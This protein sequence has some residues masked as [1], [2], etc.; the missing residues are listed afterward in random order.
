MGKF[1]WFLVY[2]ASIFVLFC[3][4]LG[5]MAVI[6]VSVQTLFDVIAPDLQITD[7]S[8]KLPRIPNTGDLLATLSLFLGVP[9]II[10]KERLENWDFK[11]R[12]WMQDKGLRYIAKKVSSVINKILEKGRW[13]I[14]LIII[15]IFA[16]AVLRG[17]FDFG[18]GMPLF[19]L[20]FFIVVIIAYIAIG[21][22]VIIG[23]FFIPFYLMGFLIPT[24]LI[25]YRV[26]SKLGA[27]DSLE[28]TLLFLALITGTLAYWINK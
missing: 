2:L 15:T 21:V 6:I 3:I 20:L 27:K 28:R 12:S 10:G 14:F 9:S 11:L 22:G 18:E 17:Y 23:L 1:E 13:V 25:P 8:I 5:G 19:G 26:I 16:I 7:I 4:L 24:L